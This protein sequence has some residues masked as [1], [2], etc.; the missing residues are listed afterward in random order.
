MK[1]KETFYTG[2]RSEWRNWLA[3][4]LETQNEI[5]FVFPLKGSSEP[6]LSYNDAVEEALCFGWIDSTA[7][8][9][10]DKHGIRRFTPRKNLRNV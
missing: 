3:E 7:G 2:K 1:Q 9:L 6:A 5:W 8:R 10:D 4:N